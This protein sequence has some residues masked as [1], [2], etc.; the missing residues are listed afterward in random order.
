M[1]FEANPSPAIAAVGEW[2]ACIPAEE[3][4]DWR[5]SEFLW[6]RLSPY[7][8]EKYRCRH[9]G[10]FTRLIGDFSLCHDL[11]PFEFRSLNAKKFCHVDDLVG[12]HEIRGLRAEFFYARSKLSALHGFR[13][14]QANTTGTFL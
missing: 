4:P 7:L 8:D 12:T 3:H 13:D 14:L 5:E 2:A 6:L 10:Y 9:S 1:S 11:D